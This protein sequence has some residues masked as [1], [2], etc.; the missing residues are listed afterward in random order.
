MPCLCNV[1]PA[2][3]TLRL[4]LGPSTFSADREVGERVPF[5]SFSPNGTICLAY[6]PLFASILRS[7]TPKHAHAGTGHV[8]VLFLCLF[9]LALA[10]GTWP[11]RVSFDLMRRGIGIGPILF[12]VKWSRSFRSSQMPS[13]HASPAASVKLSAT[14]ALS[15]SALCASCCFLLV[16]AL[17]LWTTHPF[18]FSGGV[19]LLS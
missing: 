11:W 8:V 2:Q 9:L 10:R 3:H 12:R 15:Y 14:N 13:G 16:L 6:A 18:V 5:P 19:A 4:S 1:H 7:Q 17:G